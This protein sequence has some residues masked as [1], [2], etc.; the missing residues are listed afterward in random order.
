MDAPGWIVGDCI[1]FVCDYLLPRSSYES[2][3]TLRRCSF[4]GKHNRELVLAHPQAI[5]KL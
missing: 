5:E 3:Y 1:S 2:L 4:S